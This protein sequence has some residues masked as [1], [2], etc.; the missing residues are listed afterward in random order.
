MV[1]IISLALGGLLRFVPEMFKLWDKQR[2]RVHEKEMF[3]LQL[4]A[5]EQR[6]K[7]EIQKLEKQADIELN[8]SEMDAL[9]AATKAQSVAFEKTG[10]RYLDALLVCAEVLSATVRPVLTYWYCV[11]MYGAYK[12]AT[13]VLALR[14]GGD[15]A[16]T[17]TVLWTVADAGVMSSIIGFWF[18]DRSMRKGK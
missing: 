12:I 8:K 2:E 10:N 18:V 4:R 16:T 11:A 17:V 13:L 1:E 14:A 5:D 7:I 3:D 9:I 6:A 15:F